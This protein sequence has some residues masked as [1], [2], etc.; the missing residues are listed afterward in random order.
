MGIDSHGIGAIW[1]F[2]VFV[3]DTIILNALLRL[4]K[5]WLQIGILISMAIAG[6][7]IGRGVLLPFYLPQ[8]LV[9]E[10]TCMPVYAVKR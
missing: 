3:L 10:G 5:I 1:F 6:I 8:V 7:Y 4:E 2:V 9:G